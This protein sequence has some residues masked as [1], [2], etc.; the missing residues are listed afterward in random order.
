[1]EDRVEGGPAE[2]QLEE[3]RAAC[4][5]KLEQERKAKQEINDEM[6]KPT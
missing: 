1:M 6:T 5:Q 3:L 2:H 4:P